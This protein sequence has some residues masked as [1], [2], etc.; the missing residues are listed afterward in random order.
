MS[1]RGSQQ[2]FAAFRNLQNGKN[3][4]WSKDLQKYQ[5]QRFHPKLSFNI[6]IAMCNI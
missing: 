2:F 1:E 3:H 5:N 4:F 6:N